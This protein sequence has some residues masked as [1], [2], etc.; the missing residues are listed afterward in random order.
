MFMC[1]IN[2][3]K[4]NPVFVKLKIS[5]WDNI[6]MQLNTFPHVIFRQITSEFYIKKILYNGNFFSLI[7]VPNMF[8]IGFVW[9]T[10]VFQFLRL[11]TVGLKVLMALERSGGWAEAG[12]GGWYRHCFADT[13]WFASGALPFFVWVVSPFVQSRCWQPVQN[14]CVPYYKEPAWAVRDS[15][16]VQTWSAV[17]WWWWRCARLLLEQH[18]VPCLAL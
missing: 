14:Q 2:K 8:L 12:S 15:Q 13:Q 11:Y 5:H 6:F 17:V 16:Q 10:C 1:V 9:F 3:K 7:E 18:R 4:I